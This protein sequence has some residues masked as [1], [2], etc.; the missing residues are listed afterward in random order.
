MA[1]IPG[2]HFFQVA[3]ASYWL[4]ANFGAGPAIPINYDQK[5]YDD[6]NCVTTSPTAWQYKAKYAGTYE[7]Q[8]FG[9]DTT[10]VNFLVYKNGNLYTQLLFNISSSNGNSAIVPVP[11]AVNDTIDIRPNSFTTVVGGAISAGTN[12]NKVYIK[13]VGV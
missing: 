10:N 2:I 6:E 5:E 1:K 13:R 4:S 12:T 3:K 9:Y 8:I 7:V 11:M